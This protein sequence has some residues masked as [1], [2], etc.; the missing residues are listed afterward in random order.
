MSKD[1]FLFLIQLTSTRREFGNLSIRLLCNVGDK[2]PFCFLFQ[3][4]LL[5]FFDV[6]RTTITPERKEESKL[7]ANKFVHPADLQANEFR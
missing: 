7:L 5:L 4:P 6:I 1:R 3:I 2:P